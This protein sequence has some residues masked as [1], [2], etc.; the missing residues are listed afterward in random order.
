MKHEYFDRAN[1]AE[2]RSSLIG[3]GLADSMKQEPSRFLRDIQSAGD[4]TRTDSIPAITEH[5]KR[6]HPFVESQRAILEHCAD[7]EGELL[8]TAL[9]VP[10]SAGLHE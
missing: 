3:H 5:P 10:E 1:I 4:L 8:F 9:A 2:L 6:T 7:F